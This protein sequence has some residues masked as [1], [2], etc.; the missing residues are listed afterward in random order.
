MHP[1]LRLHS[2]EQQQVV[3]HGL[4]VE[5][6]LTAHNLK[7]RPHQHQ[8]VVRA[9]IHPADIFPS[10]KGADGLLG[11]EPLLRGEGDALDVLP[12]IA[13][14]HVDIEILTVIISAPHIGLVEQVCLLEPDG[15]VRL[16]LQGVGLHR[17]GV[18]RAGHPQERRQQDQPQ[19]GGS[20]A[21]FH[22]SVLS[23]SGRPV[24]RGHIGGIGKAHLLQQLL[25][26]HMS[27]PSSL[28]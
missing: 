21:V 28:R 6:D 18:G 25:P 24:R 26:I 3:G 14:A 12:F 27:Y 10:G 2:P 16:L 19:A 17:K 11:K 4:A 22:P 5:G 15:A 20:N 9:D 7:L 1:C 13:E 8:G 23:L